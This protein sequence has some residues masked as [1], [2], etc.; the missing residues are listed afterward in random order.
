ML[1]VTLDASF[2]SRAL[3]TLMGT[4]AGF[5]F[6][7]VV[8]YISEHVKRS[9]D[10]K[11]IIIGLKREAA[12]NLGLCDAWLKSIATVRLKL[13]ADDHD[14]FNYFDY[15]RGLRVFVQEALR[16]GVLYDLLG[17]PDLVDLDKS[18]RFLSP[19]SEMDIN[20]KI[21]QWKDGAV[22]AADLS[23]ALN[24][25]EYAVTEARKAMERLG[26]KAAAA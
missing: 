3:A 1:G 17:D 9:R 4:V 12:F 23:K 2:W 5:L 24:F 22:A 14:F 19:Q 25:H 26:F 15:T 10:R 11:K 16:A 8:F 6:S 21:T 13:A 18:L 7:I 20:G